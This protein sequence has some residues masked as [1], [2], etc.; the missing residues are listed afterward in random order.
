MARCYY[1]A[2]SA[3][4]VPILPATTKPHRWF[5]NS[6]TT[7]VPAFQNRAININ[8]SNKRLYEFPVPILYT[9]QRVIN[10]VGANNFQSP[11]RFSP[12]HNR[13]PHGLPS[14]FKRNNVNNAP[15]NNLSLQSVSAQ[16][17]PAFIYISAEKSVQN[18]PRL[19]NKKK[20][21]FVFLSSD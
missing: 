13:S 19:K 9:P 18:R 4:S 14:N 10:L 8:H 17:F 6:S 15:K 21:K 3:H 11:L 12:A 1:L 16:N 2:N 20:G 7:Q 5:L